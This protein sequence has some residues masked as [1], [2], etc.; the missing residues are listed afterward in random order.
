[1]F[2]GT[3]ITTARPTSR[4][5]GPGAPLKMRA[6]NNIIFFLLIFFF[7]ASRSR[8]RLGYYHRLSN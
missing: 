1:L 2:Q 7:Q 5:K 8:E 3:S 4:S 6:K